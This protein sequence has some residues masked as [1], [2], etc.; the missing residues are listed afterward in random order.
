[1]SLVTNLQNAF[2]RI[3]TEFKTIRTEIAAAQAAASARANHTGTQS[4][5]TILDGT[6]NKVLTA[7][8]STKL[9]GI[10]TGA[11]A[12]SPDATLLARANHTGTQSA[13]TII[14]GTT[15][16]AYTAAEKTKL[17]TVASGATANSTDATLLGRGNHTGTQLANTISNFDT[18]VRT[19]RLDQMA[20]PTASVSMGTQKII[21]VV[22]PTLPQD[23]STK[24]YTD[25]G[26]TAAKARANH[27]GTQSADTLTDGTTNKAFLA[28]ERTK[29]TGIATGATANSADATLLARGN[30]TGTQTASTI[31][32]FNTAADARVAAQVGSL[33]ALTTTTK[34]SAVAAIN[35]L[36]AAVDALAAGSGAI[37]DGTTSSST[38]WSSTKT[39]TEIAAA[40]AAIVGGSSAAL[41]TLNE[42]AT[43]LGND[44]NF[45]TTTATALGNRVRVDA[46]QSFT[47]PQ[48]TQ[49]R[50]NI[51][52]VATTEVGDTTTNFQTTFEAALV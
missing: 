48:K 22:D 32:D 14:D 46:V 25:T 1:M 41:D 23:A 7:A 12:N 3:G 35:E 40:A 47:A 44:A 8:A 42:F 38:T 27:T 26:D 13:D 2:T 34:T 49:A 36:D 9:T 28:T 50:A 15:N 16:K 21:S 33:A 20:A 30:H 11:T 19:S 31:S 37:S 39:S 51:D 18:Q 45:A 5:D 29:L 6:T 17:G 52:A 24:A 43:A 4:A 10:A